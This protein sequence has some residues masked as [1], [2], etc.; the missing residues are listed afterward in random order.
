MRI[1]IFNNYMYY[2]EFFHTH[3]TYYKNPLYLYINSYFLETSNIDIYYYL[4]K[5]FEY[6]IVFFR[7][8]KSLE[9]IKD[10][11][12]KLKFEYNTFESIP[13]FYKKRNENINL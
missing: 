11:F 6:S 13:F 7:Y 2:F 10:L 5:Y 3:S 1:L 8:K 9:N 12:L 4:V